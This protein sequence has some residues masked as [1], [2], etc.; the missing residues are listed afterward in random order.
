MSKKIAA[1]GEVMMRMQ[2]PENLLLTQANS[3]QYSFSGTGVN[4]TGSIEKLGYESALISTLPAN[5]IGDAA[6]S[7]LQKLGIS[8]DYIA[9][10]GNYIGMYFLENGIGARPSRVTY[11]NRM[12]SS[13]NTA[14]KSNYSFHKIAE[15]IDL[16]HVCGI[17]LAMNENVRQQMIRLANLVKEQG[18]TVLFDCN[19]R[20]SL[21]GE[22]GH[23]KAKPYYD[24]LL[25][26]A[27]MVMMNE[28]DAL[29]TLEYHCQHQEREKQLEELIPKVA[30]D[31]NIA[32]IAGTH[33]TIHRDD[34]HSIKGYLYQA[35]KFHYAK[36]EQFRVLDR[37]GA[38]DA[39][40]TGIIHGKLQD[41][42]PQQTIQ[43]A[44]ASCMLAHTIVG[45]TPLST[46]QEILQ[47]SNHQIRDVIR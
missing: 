5:P 12:E 11:S 16:L 20:P 6:I 9:R 36:Q 45:D 21:W 28:K 1:F 8:T 17:T 44:T 43:F 27:D 33:R 31:Y 26:I 37:I 25:N 32:M 19:Y 3:L 14:S 29:Y 7:H 39:F 41:F 34:S 42:Q 10:S 40:A 38:G 15:E 47:A 46:K 23:L 4:I 13:F 24:Q 18:G 35:G 30:D 22:N 2:V